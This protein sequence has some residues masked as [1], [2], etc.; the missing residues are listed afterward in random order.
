MY[1]MATLLRHG[2]E[3]Q[4]QR[5]LPKIA[6]GELRL[7]AFGVTEP[8][9]GSDTSRI[10][11]FAHRIYGGYVVS[12]Q[13][14]WTSRAL[15][16]DLLLLLAR[17]TARDEVDKPTDGLSVFLVDLRANADSIRI[18]PIETMLNHHTTEL[19]LDEVLVP[20][21]GLIGEEGDGFR[22]ILSGMNAER[23][24]IAA[25]CIGDGRWFIE[26][27]KR[28]ASERVVFGRAIGS[29]QGVQ[30]PIARAHLAV[31]A[32]DLM[33]FEAARRH[34]DGDPCGEE[35]NSAKYLASEASWMA[36]NVAMDTYGGFGFAREYDIERKFRETRLYRTAPVA[37]NL[38][39]SYVGHHVLG[40]PR[41]Y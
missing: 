24:L 22:C 4:R 26:K 10:Q 21:D 37:N 6:S 5:F 30:F 32:A 2:T 9:A 16:S 36:A 40:M 7:Q 34:D 41:S 28:Y 31:R 35:A 8:D 18:T 3:Q 27:A 1:T 19:F 25:E 23:I 39:L 20:D 33:R 12:G 13:K 17:T 11:T 15:H 14:I 38:I 29:N